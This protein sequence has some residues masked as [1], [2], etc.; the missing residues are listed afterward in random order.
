V[1]I[2]SLLVRLEIGSCMKNIKKLRRSSKNSIFAGICGG[3]GE[4]MAI[5]PVVIRLVW[6]FI[7]LVTGIFPGVFVYIIAIFII[8]KDTDR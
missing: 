8:P 7:V 4:Y 2:L 5:D 3:M 1:H 6:I